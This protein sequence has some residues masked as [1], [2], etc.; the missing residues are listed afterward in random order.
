VAHSAATPAPQRATTKR[1]KRNADRRI[2]G[3]RVDVA[4]AFLKDA[5]SHGAKPQAEVE[6][7]AQKRHITPNSLGRA[8]RNVAV[9]A[10]RPAAANGSG[11]LVRALPT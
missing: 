1:A 6:G 10:G 2:T 7:E 4:T 11:E 8:R 9:V 5:L 3:P